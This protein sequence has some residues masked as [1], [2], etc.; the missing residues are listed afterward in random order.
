M[1]E[2]EIRSHPG[3]PSTGG[4]THVNMLHSCRTVTEAR[5]A[6]G[7]IGLGVFLVPMMEGFPLLEQLGLVAEECP[8]GFRKFHT[9]C[10]ICKLGRPCPAGTR[11]VVPR[12]LWDW[13]RAWRDAIQGTRRRLPAELL[14]LLLPCAEGDLG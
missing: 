11:A 9:A 13:L 4:H 3:R 14:P 8:A 1:T 2:T 7:V 10:R 12:R 6:C 5:T